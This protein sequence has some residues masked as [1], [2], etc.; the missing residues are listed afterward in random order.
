MPFLD[1][2]EEQINLLFENAIPVSLKKE[3]EDK[4]KKEYEEYKENKSFKKINELKPLTVYFII[5]DLKGN[6]QIQFIKEND[7]INCL[8][9]I[10]SEE[11]GKVEDFELI[12]VKDYKSG[13]CNEDWYILVDK[14]GNVEKY[15]CTRDPYAGKE[16]NEIIKYYERDKK[17]AR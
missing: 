1:L 8:R 3:D 9:Y 5:R 11:C 4:A 16:F 13:W 14:E 7:V 12:D 10:K 17:S 2:T 6:E 15:I